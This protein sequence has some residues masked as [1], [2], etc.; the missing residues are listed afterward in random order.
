MDVLQNPS[1]IDS[2]QFDL[3]YDSLYNKGN[4]LYNDPRYTEPFRAMYR[5]L[6]VLIESIRYD[7]T[8]SQ[9]AYD[10]S[11]I[12]R[13][14][15]LDRYGKPSLSVMTTGIN[16]LRS[17]LGPIL[18]RNLENVPVPGTSGEDDTY[19]WRIESMVVN[20]AELVPDR[21]DFKMW[22]AATVSLTTTQSEAVTYLTM[23]IRD[24]QVSASNLKFWFQRK[25][26]PK[27][28]EEG[29]ADVGITGRNELRVTWVIRGKQDENWL[30]DIHEV[31]C[32]LDNVDITVKESTHTILMKLLTT[33]FSGTIRRNIEN[34]IEENV[35]TGLLNINDQI[36]AALK[37]Y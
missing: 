37:G 1:I 22:G 5:D 28:E 24:V 25:V 32:N 9:F 34:K 30:L 17:L 10:S 2:E 6:R 16:N 8:T 35:K 20:M 31:K 3:R 36:I 18:K 23:W 26:I 15:F 11:R 7:R 13:D 33:L 21:L 29:V 14:L 27:L 12:A 19:K 4:A